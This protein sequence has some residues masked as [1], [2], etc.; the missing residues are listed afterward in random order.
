MH[1][2]MSKTL[3]QQLLELIRAVGCTAKS[4]GKGGFLVSESTDIDLFVPHW[5]WIGKVKR[6]KSD[7]GRAKPD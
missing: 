5:T 2:D 6:Q 1:G 3:N 7:T 4:N